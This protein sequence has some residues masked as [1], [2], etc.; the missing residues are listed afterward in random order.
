ME[1]AVTVYDGDKVVLS[2][3]SW[4]GKTSDE[5]PLNPVAELRERAMETRDI[6]WRREKIAQVGKLIEENVAA[7][8]Q[9]QEEDGVTPS[10]FFGASKMVFGAVQYYQAL[11]GKW[12]A[13]TPIEDTLPPPMR[14]PELTSRACSTDLRGPR[15]AAR[16]RAAAMTSM[17]QTGSGVPLNVPQRPSAGGR[18]HD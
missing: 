16:K 13:P 10:N 17:E 12:A 18:G 15:R 11:V 9:A 1:A 8:T 14:V 6:A 2:T 5:P 4:F 7:I 3:A